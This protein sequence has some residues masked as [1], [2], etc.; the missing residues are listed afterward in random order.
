MRVRYLITA[1]LLALLLPIRAFAVDGFSQAFD[2]AGPAAGATTT[3]SM[4][5]I[6]AGCAG[7]LFIT[8]KSESRSVSS[9]VDSAG[10]T[11]TSLVGDQSNAGNGERFATWGAGNLAAG[12]HTLTI[13]FDAG[14]QS[15]SMAAALEYCGVT[16]SPFDVAASVQQSSGATGWTV[17]PTASTAQ[18]DEYVVSGASSTTASRP[19]TT[20]SGFTR[21]VNLLTTQFVVADKTVAAT[22]TQSAQWDVTGGN[23]LGEASIV[24]LKAAAAVSTCNGGLSLLGVGKGC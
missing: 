13:T 15:G 20:P 23:S 24:T 2:N 21:R 19:F 14:S 8:M 16:T 6:T 17:G 7:V 5:S 9:V 12:A 1:G 10:D 3:V 22:G 11:W 4:T 18:A